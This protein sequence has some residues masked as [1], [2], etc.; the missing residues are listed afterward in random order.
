MCKAISILASNEGGSPI[1]CLHIIG[2]TICHVEIGR[3]DRLCPTAHGGELFGGRKCADA[4][5]LY[6]L[7]FWRGINGLCSHTIC[8]K[9]CLSTKDTEPWGECQAPFFRC[10]DEQERCSSSPPF[11]LENPMRIPSWKI[12]PMGKIFVLLLSSSVEA[13]CTFSVRFTLMADAIG[14]HPFFAYVG[15]ISLKEVEREDAWMRSMLAQEWFRDFLCS[16]HRIGSREISSPSISREK[17][18]QQKV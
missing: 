17:A 16:L 7:K 12:L 11:R 2:R 4:C 15:T 18:H 6:P 9:L 8:S 5:N 10:F 13:C 1:T 14:V 3:G